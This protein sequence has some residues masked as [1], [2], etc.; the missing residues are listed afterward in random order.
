MT[1]AGPG[2]RYTKTFKKYKGESDP[3]VID[4]V[5]GWARSETLHAVHEDASIIKVTGTQE[6]IEALLADLK[7]RFGYIPPELREE[8]KVEEEPEA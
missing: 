1:D 4:Y 3:R 8:K 5:R 2:I 7:A 6:Q